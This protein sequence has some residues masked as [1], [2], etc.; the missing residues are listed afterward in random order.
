MFGNRSLFDRDFTSD[1]QKPAKVKK[2]KRPQSGVRFT[3]NLNE[4]QKDSFGNFING[5]SYRRFRVEIYTRDGF[6]CLKCGNKNNL[7]LDHIKPISKGGKGIIENLQTL[8]SNCNCLKG[9]KEIDYRKINV[10]LPI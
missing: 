3:G 9:N 8:C 7:T 1:R 5:N 6:A 2:P 4:L 10:A